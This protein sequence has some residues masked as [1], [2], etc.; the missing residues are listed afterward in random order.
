MGLSCSSTIVSFVFKN[1]ELITHAIYW[2]SYHL[3]VL[4][5]HHQGYLSF[6]LRDL[7]LY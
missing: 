5:F 2:L 1:N 6:N 4:I 3:V 7:S